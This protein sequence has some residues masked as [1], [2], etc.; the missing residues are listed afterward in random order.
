[1]TGPKTTIDPVIHRS[2]T[3][4]AHPLGLPLI[5]LSL[6]ESPWPPSPL[7][8][9][10]ARARSSSGNRYPDQF[11]SDL[12]EAIA[13]TYHLHPEHLV[14]GNGSEELLDVIGRAFVRPGDQILIS[15]HGYIQFPLVAARLGAEMV[16]AKETDCVANVDNLLAAVT[17]A[18]K[19]VFLAVPNNPTGTNVPVAEVERLV[20]SLPSDVALVLDLAYGEYVCVANLFESFRIGGVPRWLGPRCT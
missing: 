2:T 18:T 4:A 7:V 17:P 12:R 10:A 5:D 6:N 15:E 13:R 3:R 20:G 16:R 9:E 14:V 1:M 11:S 8:T 19:L